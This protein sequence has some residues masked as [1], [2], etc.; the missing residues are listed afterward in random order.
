[1]PKDTDPMEKVKTKIEL[2]FQ[3]HIECRCTEMH[4]TIKEEKK[5]KSKDLN[6]M[7][8]YLSSSGGEE[9]EH[10][11]NDVNFDTESGEEENYNGN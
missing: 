1:M 3:H 4:L 8:S 5:W 6:V 11:S 9:E 10:D 7:E 2:L